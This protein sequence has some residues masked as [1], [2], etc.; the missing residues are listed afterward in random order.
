MMKNLKHLSND[1]RIHYSVILLV[2]IL[3]IT[4][5]FFSGIPYLNVD[6]VHHL[7]IS[8]AFYDS[9]RQGI[10]FPDWVTREN[11]GYGAV[12]V[13]FYPPSMDYTL[14]V[15]RLITGSWNLAIF[16]AFSFW[17]FIGGVGVYIWTR[18][19]LKTGWH[20]T[21]AAVLFICAPYHLCQFYNSFMF[22]EFAALSVLPFCFHF[23][24]KICEREKIVDIL[25]LAVAAALMILSNLPQ[26]I[27]SFITIGIYVSFFL[28][29]PFFLKQIF[30]LACAGL[31]ALAGSAFYWVRMVIE[32]NLIHVAQPN[33]DPTYDYQNHFM[34]ADFSFDIQNIWFSTLMFT[35]VIIVTGFVLVIT[36]KYKSLWQAKNLRAVSIVTVAAIFMMTLGSKFIWD[37]ITFL[38]RVQFPWRFFSVLSLCTSVIMAYCAEFLT[39]E[40]LR[41]KRPLIL[42]FIGSIL[43]LLTFSIKQVIFGTVFL[44]PSKFPAYVEDTIT[45]RSLKHWLPVWA[46]IDSFKE[47][48]KVL[49]NGREVNIE[50][51]EADRKV[52]TVSE[53]E[54]TTARIAVLYYPHWHAYLNG[55]NVE[56]SPDGDGAIALPLPDSDSKVE[57]VF[58]EPQYSL[59]SRKISVVAAILVF[60]LFIYQ[61]ISRRKSNAG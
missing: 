53:G 51:W 52:F 44:E 30:K 6:L 15:F 11:F 27:L 43:I 55:K 35:I 5:V 18:D 31:L 59:L 37:N 2:S 25:G 23:A 47:K 16:G 22:G 7:Q 19:F 38:Q 14:A 40:N 17:S 61:I 13:R 42:L 60:L 34:L 33:T 46:D 41:Q 54:T 26:T 8:N 20:S 50:I 57:L 29:K 28:K 3:V 10:L 48:T 32:M 49:T 24:K 39:L 56:I 36:G 4:P 45:K 1:S 21:L 58:I 12:T 9:L